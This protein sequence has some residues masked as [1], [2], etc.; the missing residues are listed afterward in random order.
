M[1]SRLRYRRKDRGVDAV[2]VIQNIAVPE[3]EH[4]SA[5]RREVSGAGFVAFD[6]FTVVAAV[7][8]DTDC[9]LSTRDVED[10]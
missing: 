5:V 6:L 2:E 7:E 9:E 10:V 8:L 4:R 3:A 1:G